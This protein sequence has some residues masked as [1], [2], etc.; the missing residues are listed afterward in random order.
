MSASA[1]RR[2][3]AGL[4]SFWIHPYIGKPSA[5][6]KLISAL[7][8]T[9]VARHHVRPVHHYLCGTLLGLSAYY[10]CILSVRGVQKFHGS[11][12]REKECYESQCG[13]AVLLRCSLTQP[14]ANRHRCPLQAAECCKNICYFVEHEQQRPDSSYLV[15]CIMERMPKNY[16]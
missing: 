12:M 11:T 5:L 2:S 8:Y 7:W 16:M 9:G 6:G 14:S 1:A 13:N 4:S 10:V 3:C 15:H